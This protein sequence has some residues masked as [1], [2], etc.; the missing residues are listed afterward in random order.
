MRADFTP[1]Y[2]SVSVNTN[3][4]Q[5]VKRHESL[6]F[7]NETECVSTVVGVGGDEEAARL[8]IFWIKAYSICMWQ[9]GNR[10]EVK[11]FP[12]HHP[13]HANF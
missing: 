3:K 10:Q 6:F 1:G 11:D 13:K 5:T 2:L 9:W 8:M 4:P 7:L 12:N